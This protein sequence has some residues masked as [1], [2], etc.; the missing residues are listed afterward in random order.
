MEGKVYFGDRQR[1]RKKEPFSFTLPNGTIQWVVEQLV[2][3]YN[4]I[5]A[6]RQHKA[7]RQV[8]THKKGN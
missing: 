2:S 4:G 8:C 5:I 1:P 6:I 3:M 7:A